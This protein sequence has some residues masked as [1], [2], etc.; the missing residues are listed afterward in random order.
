MQKNFGN[1]LKDYA[2]L[3]NDYAALRTKK[4]APDHSA[5]VMELQKKLKDALTRLKQQNPDKKTTREQ[6]LLAQDIVNL[7]NE[8]HRDRQELLIARAQV[9]RLKQLEKQTAE[10]NKQLAGEKKSHA[11]TGNDLKELKAEQQDLMDKLQLN[12]TELEETE[13]ARR[14]LVLRLEAV[15]KE[16]IAL[17]KKVRAQDARIAELSKIEAEHKRLWPP[18]LSSRSKTR[19]SLRWSRSGKNN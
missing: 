9:L 5:K 17:K 12:M 18:L 11:K 1:T 14:A 15:E 16:N 19:V 3:Q 7:R 8:L 10:L 2:K 13:K 4:E 6:A